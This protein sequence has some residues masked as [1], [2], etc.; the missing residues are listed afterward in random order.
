[1]KRL[2]NSNT[3]LKIQPVNYMYL[4]FDQ[5]GGSSS[6]NLF[7]ATYIYFI[8]ISPDFCDIL[9]ITCKTSQISYGKRYYYHLAVQC[10]AY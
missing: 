1:M 4:S 2:A 10:S 6:G 5:Q 7:L 8:E 9:I 3:R